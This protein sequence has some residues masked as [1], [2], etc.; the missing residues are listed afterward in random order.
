MAGAHAIVESMQSRSH[1]QRLDTGDISL[2]QVTNNIS[3]NKGLAG[4]V[5]SLGIPG[6]GEGT[7][8]SL[9]Q[10]F[11]SMDALMSANSE[12]LGRVEQVSPRISTAGSVLI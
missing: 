11:G 12:E 3:I 8:D 5:A 10:V 4:V 7:A 9:A 1:A 6:V 2:Q